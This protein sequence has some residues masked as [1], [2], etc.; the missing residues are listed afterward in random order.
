MA[1]PSRI[2]R[3]ETLIVKTDEESRSKKL[4]IIKL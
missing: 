3:R 2:H 4:R 1:K